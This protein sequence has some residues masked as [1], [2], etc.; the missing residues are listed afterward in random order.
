M[1]E[2]RRGKPRRLFVCPLCVAKMSGVAP[3]RPRKS[4]G[5]Q[6]TLGNLPPAAFVNF[7]SQNSHL[8]VGSC[9]VAGKKNEEEPQEPDARTRQ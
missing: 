2:S 8:A 7:P 5:V 1:D 9:A 3:A 6:V 4:R